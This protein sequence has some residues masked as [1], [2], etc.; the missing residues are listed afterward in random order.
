MK[1]ITLASLGLIIV[2]SL[3]CSEKLDVEKEQAAIKKVIIEET[4]AFDNQDYE[5]II[6]TLVHDSLL[7][8]LST[9]KV[10]HAEVSGWE[11]MAPWYKDFTEAELSDY[12]VKRERSNWRIKVYQNSAWAVY[13]Q[14][15]RFTYKGIADDRTTREIRFL[16]KVDGEWKIV[17]LQVIYVSSYE[18]DEILE[19]SIYQDEEVEE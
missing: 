10:E 15:T 8:R 6:N 4:T 18:V 7:I 2:L 3:S 5:G 9:G 12:S 13:D 11:N 14:V 1:K 17:M 16:E 19:Y